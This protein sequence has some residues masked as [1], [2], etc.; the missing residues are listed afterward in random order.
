MSENA[1]SEKPP[2]FK[3]WSGWYWLVVFA[4]IIQFLFYFFIT[5]SFS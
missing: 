3:T 5:R 2:V 4:T 1:E